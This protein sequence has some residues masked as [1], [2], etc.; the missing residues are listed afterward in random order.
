MSL[1]IL[2]I[3]L[4][5]LNIWELFE[6]QSDQIADVKFPAFGRTCADQIHIG[7]AIVDLKFAVA[8]ETIVNTDPTIG[9]TF[10]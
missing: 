6:I 9:I 10:G 3:D 1:P 2:V 5:E 4:H 7:N 8:R